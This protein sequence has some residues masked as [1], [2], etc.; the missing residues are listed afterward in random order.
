MFGVFE[1]IYIY[2]CRYIYIYIHIYIYRVLR[3]VVESLPLDWEYA[4]GCARFLVATWARGS[5]LA[6]K[7]LN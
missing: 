1:V 3:P 6:L 4:S 7:K 5:G 2:I